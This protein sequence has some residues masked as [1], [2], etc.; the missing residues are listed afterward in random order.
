M[1]LDGVMYFNKNSLL[2]R[3]ISATLEWIPTT[4]TE[5]LVDELTSGY[6]ERVLQNV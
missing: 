6:S 3:H 5:E 4:L 2:C 1:F